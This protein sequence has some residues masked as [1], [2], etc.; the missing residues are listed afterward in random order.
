[1]IDIDRSV[2][3]AIGIRF[4]RSRK[5]ILCFSLFQTRL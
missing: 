3:R 2:D 4:R 1:M 5:W